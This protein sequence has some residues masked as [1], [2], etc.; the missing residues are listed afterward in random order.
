MFCEGNMDFLVHNWF[1]ILILALFVGM[2]VTGFGC[3]HRHSRL[4]NTGAGRQV[5]AETG[6]PRGGTDAGAP[7]PKPPGIAPLI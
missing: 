3:G 2:H 5:G 4:H 1:Y 6:T 7:I